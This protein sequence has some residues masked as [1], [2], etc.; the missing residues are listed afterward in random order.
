M[1]TFVFL[2]ALVVGWAIIRWGLELT[3]KVLKYGF[4]WAIIAYCVATALGVVK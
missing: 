3:F 4:A 1:N 2:I